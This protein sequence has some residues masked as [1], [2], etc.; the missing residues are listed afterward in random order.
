[1]LKTNPYPSR[2]RIN[3]AININTVEELWEFC[4]R[5]VFCNHYYE[6]LAA[7]EN[8]S[9]LFFKHIVFY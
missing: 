2:L 9:K 4:K 8:T 7:M 3:G 6:I 1:M 5:N